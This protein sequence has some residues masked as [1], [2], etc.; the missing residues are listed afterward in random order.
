V[1]VYNEEQAQTSTRRVRCDRRS[2]RRRC[3]ARERGQLD[4]DGNTVSVGVEHGN[5][6][7]VEHHDAE[8]DDRPQ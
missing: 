6:H 5:D 3:G 8:L 1:E 4:G 7:D 2:C